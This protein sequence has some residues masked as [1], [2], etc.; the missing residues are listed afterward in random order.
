MHIFKN[1]KYGLIIT[2]QFTHLPETQLLVKWNIFLKKQ[3]VMVNTKTFVQSAPEVNDPPY[4]YTQ[5][6]SFGAFSKPQAFLSFVFT[7]CQVWHFKRT[8]KKFKKLFISLSK[9][10]FIT[11]VLMYKI[12]LHLKFEKI[13]KKEIKVLWPN[14]CVIEWRNPVMFGDYRKIVSQIP[15]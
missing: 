4:K 13:S 1:V 14:I 9:K 3:C 8:P 12:G 11:T 7:S 5:Q 2:L 10:L 15:I 6:I